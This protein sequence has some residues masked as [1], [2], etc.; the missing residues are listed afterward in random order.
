MPRSKPPPPRGASSAHTPNP[1][2]SPKKSLAR[3]IL[4]FLGCLLRG[5]AARA[6]RLWIW[7]I[8]AA[9]WCL[10]WIWKNPWKSTKTVVNIFFRIAT[11]TSV[12]YL[13]FDRIYETSGIISSPSS[14][15]QDPFLFPF[16]VDNNSHLF[17]LRNIAWNCIADRI[18]TDKQQ[19]LGPNMNIGFGTQS[20]IAAGHRTNVSCNVFG[21]S[22]PVM[23]TPGAKVT[24]A[25]IRIELTY[26]VDI[27]GHLWHRSPSP[28]KFTWFPQASN[29]Q[30]VKG[31]IIETPRRATLSGRSRE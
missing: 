7:V 27:F 25:E 8:D 13:V 5:L 9:I 4:R 15:P 12:G 11:L 10:L 19:S 1:A 23:H 18:E 20:E 22:A 16:A 31:D 3:A 28:I 2:Q 30:W 29:P 6:I 17:Q 21:P 24:K 14:D 26:D